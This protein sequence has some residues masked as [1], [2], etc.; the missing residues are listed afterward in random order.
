MMT[1]PASAAPIAIHVRA[2]TRSRISSH[3]KSAARKGAIAWNSSTCARLVEPSARMKQLEAIATPIATPMPAT[4][5]LRKAA[6]VAPRRR[7]TRYAVSAI[8]A[9]PARIA[10]WV[11]AGAPTKRCTGPAVDHATA[12]AA[13]S[14]WPRRSGSAT[15]IMPRA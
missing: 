13:T 4:P 11:G 9:A 6:N 2:G 5:T 7:T 8:A 14:S 10:A 12:A 15:A 3:A 1:T